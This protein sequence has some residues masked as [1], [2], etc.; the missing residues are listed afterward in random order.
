MN[1][2][3]KIYMHVF[4]F[5]GENTFIENLYLYIIYLFVTIVCKHES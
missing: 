2:T 3:D 5:G 4:D 1:F